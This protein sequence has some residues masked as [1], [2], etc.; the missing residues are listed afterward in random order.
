MMITQGQKQALIDNLQLES[1][2]LD[3]QSESSLIFRAVTER[4]RKLRAQY[5]LQAQSLRTRVELRVNRIPK[6][7]RTAKMGDLLL[8]YAESRRQEAEAAVKPIAQPAPND[9]TRK[10]VTVDETKAVM[11]AAYTQSRGTKRTR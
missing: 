6:N 1:E 8:R 11:P 9:T 3:L 2:H 7:L 10:K 5:A 4:A